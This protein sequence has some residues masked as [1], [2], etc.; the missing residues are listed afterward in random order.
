MQTKIYN[1]TLQKTQDKQYIEMLYD[2]IYNEYYWSEDWSQ[3]F[4]ITLAKLGFISTS[5]DTKD[6]LVLLPELQLHYGILDFKNLHISKKVHQLINQKKYTLHFNTRFDEVIDKLAMQHKDNWCRNE[7]AQLMKQLYKERD[8]SDDFK[9]RSVEL[10]S[11]QSSELIAGEIGYQIGKTYTSL[12]GFSSKEK[13]YSN[14]GTLQLV[15]LAQHL[16]KE[17]FSFWNLGHP[18]MLYKQ[19]LGS[20]IHT[21]KK[22]LIR[23]KEATKVLP[24]S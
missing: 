6:G 4:Y 17:G 9:I 11:T 13:K 16:E 1:L 21:R 24:L 14:W 18:H 12:S 5:C 22:F 3:E 23:W 19:K 2:D 10:I 15:L 8:K 20:I 7:Y